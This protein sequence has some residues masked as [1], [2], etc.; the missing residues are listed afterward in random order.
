MPPHATSDSTTHAVIPTV[1]TAQF[2]HLTADQAETLI[3]GRYTAYLAQGHDWDTALRKAVRAD[4][5]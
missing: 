3:R 1:T 2:E 4:D 5:K